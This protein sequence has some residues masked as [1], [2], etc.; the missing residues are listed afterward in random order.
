MFLDLH[1]PT[2][3]KADIDRLI[4]EYSKNLMRLC[5]MI[6]KDIHLAEEAAWDTLYK[7]YK[8]YNNFKGNSSEKTWITRIAIN[9]CRSYMRKPSYREIK[10]SSY[11]SLNYA[12][13]DEASAEFRS[14]E[15]IALLNAVY[16]LNEKYKQVILLHYYQQMSIAEV[17][18]ILNEKEN[19]I[20]VR[21]KRAHSML[22][23]ML[24]EDLE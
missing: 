14:E 8:G 13:E 1:T 5:Y 15:S 21:L 24:K 17:A 3:H 20:S 10:N 2:E 11:I 18:E 7:A 22:K 9:V 6:L 23:E 16:N 4:N 12:S 19:T